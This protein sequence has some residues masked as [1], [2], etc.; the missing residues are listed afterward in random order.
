MVF[1]LLSLAIMLIAVI[2]AVIMKTNGD[3]SFI[4]VFSFVFIPLMLLN[5]FFNSIAYTSI[6]DRK[7]QTWLNQPQPG[8]VS[9]GLQFMMPM[10]DTESFNVCRRQVEFTGEETLKGTAKGGMQIEIM[11]AVIPIR[12]LPDHLWRVRS[13]IGGEFELFQILNGSARSAGRIVQSQYEWRDLVYSKRNEIEIAFSKELMKRLTI[14]L[15]G[16]GL[17]SEEAENVFVIPEVRL[18]DVKPSQS[19]LDEQGNY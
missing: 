16:A 6:C 19:I 13:L 10:F 11:D 15:V 8:Y 9:N 7:V 2:V 4:G 14:D 3:K 5:T 17:T 1:L 12:L 18:R